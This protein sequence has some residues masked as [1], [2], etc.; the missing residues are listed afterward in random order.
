MMTIS[1]T[2]MT[3][4]LSELEEARR[5]L[6]NAQDD[7]HITRRNLSQITHPGFRRIVCEDAYLCARRQLYAA[8]SWVWDA[9]ERASPPVLLIASSLFDGDLEAMKR[10][11]GQNN[12]VL[13][14]A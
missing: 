1:Q 2:S 8:L 12:R 14:A 6:R 13:I 10:V 3:S 11:L 9:Q 7:L 5:A 4:R